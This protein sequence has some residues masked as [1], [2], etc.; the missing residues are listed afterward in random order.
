MDFLAPIFAAVGVAAAAVPVVL[1][2]LRRA[3]TEEMPFSLVRFLKPSRPRFTRRS[4]IEHWPLM[5]L[6][7]LALA[8]IGLAFARPFLREVIPLDSD[9]GEA[10]VVMLLVDKSASMRRDGIHEQVRKV[11]QETVDALRPND[12]LSIAEFSDEYHT[13]I[14]R[15]TWQTASADERSA[16]VSQVIEN[17]SADWMSTNTGNA[18]ML[19]AEELSRET[20]DSVGI[21]QRQL[22]LVTDFQ[23]G[24]D[25]S[26]IRRDDWPAGVEVELKVVEPEKRGN[27]GISFIQDQRADRTRIRISSDGDAVAQKYSLQPFDVSGAPI[28]PEI[29]VEV[30]P[31]QRR[32]VLLPTADRSRGQSVAGVELKGDEHPFDNV[33]DLPELQNPL[34]QVAHIGPV[35]A[36]DP[37][38]MRY[39]LQ[40][41]FDGSDDRDISVIDLVDGSGVALPIPPD[42]QL[43][44][45]T[46][47]IS[48]NLHDS[49]TAFLERDGTLLVAASDVAT[50]ESAVRFLPVKVTA[51]EAVVDDYAMLEKVDF[52]HPIFSVFTDGRF[53]DFSSIRFWKY[54]TLTLPNDAATADDRSTEDD[55]ADSSS[56]NRVHVA[57]TFDSGSPAILDLEGS[58]GGRILLL[59]SGWHPVDSQ[60]ALSSRF[61]PM[62]SRVLNLASPVQKGQFLRTVGDSI[63]PKELTGTDNWKL[64]FPNGMEVTSEDTSETGGTTESP[65]SV[66]GSEPPSTKAVKLTEPGRY[67]L[68]ATTAEGDTTAMLIA[69]LAPSESRTEQLPAGQLQVLGIGVQTDDEITAESLDQDGRSPQMS[70]S[71]LEKAQ[72]WWRWLLVSGMAC[73]VLESLWSAAIDRRQ[74]AEG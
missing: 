58:D 10:R 25:L 4:T 41:V 7:I 53:A 32:S 14:S 60:W 43:T 28:G 55:P 33:L 27:A 42:V 40:R 52:S 5:L 46:G 61:P 11:V 48:L 34:V 50:I 21:T 12:Q 44:I 45:A 59:A 73:L 39:Y 49:I 37:E 16:M 2:M 74:L 54:R 13:L 29:P 57:A 30:A 36:N 3:P 65:T 69:S 62:L 17:Y 51:T 9:D 23:R 56:A 67:V 26:S 8:L 72:K 47:P 15:E 1:H 68:T 19:A 20:M 70:S 18:M 66:I 24:S 22:V 35:D 64:A 6:R 38:S 31:G 63:R 71:E